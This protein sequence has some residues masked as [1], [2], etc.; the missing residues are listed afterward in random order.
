MTNA[1]GGRVVSGSAPSKPA[2]AITVLNVLG[3]TVLGFEQAPIVPF[4]AVLAAYA[5]ELL[6]ET[7]DAA[8]RRR[9]PRFMGGV[10]TLVDFLLSAHITGLA[11][12][13]LLYTNDRLGVVV[14]TS[15]IAIASKS[16]FRVRVDGHE[17]HL[18][19]PS[20][21]GISATLLAFPWVGI[22]PPYQ[23]TENLSVTGDWAVP[24]IIVTTG[25]LLNAR[26]THRLPLIAAWL[27]VFVALASARSSL[28]RWSTSCSRAIRH[29]PW[30]SSC[31]CALALRLRPR[32]RPWTSWRLR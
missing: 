18:F 3:H 11:A 20:N 29:H 27:R 17:R 24:A 30:R 6:L 10:G 26:F 31:S 2:V 1:N 4:V 32:R 25:T 15:V 9:R 23:F 5:T 8:L 16:L 13:M 21:L 28:P 12:G 22:A 19:N 7:I 14:C